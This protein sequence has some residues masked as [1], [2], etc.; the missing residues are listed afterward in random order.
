MI[1]DNA[2]DPAVH[3]LTP[4]Q[5]DLWWR[6]HREHA[7]G[8]D[9]GVLPCYRDAA[10]AAVRHLP[11][12]VVVV[13]LGAGGGEKEAAV[14]EA[15]VANRPSRD[16]CFVAVDV[17]LELALRSV[18]AIAQMGVRADPVVGDMLAM[19]ELGGW[20]DERYPRHRR[21]VTGFGI[22]PNVRPGE[23]W[24]L[25]GSVAGAQGLALV[26]ANLFT[27]WSE[28]LP[29]YDNPETAE[30]LGQVVVDWGLQG[31]LSPVRFEASTV[32]GVPAVV[33]VCTWLRDVVVT[34]DGTAVPVAAGSD[35]RL[36]F[37]LR[38]TP[39]QVRAL[40]F[41]QGWKVEGEFV[42]A[43]GQEGVWLLRRSLPAEGPSGYEGADDGPHG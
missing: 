14:V 16:V 35:L 18:E 21:L 10:A 6:V 34:L 38:F 13:G 41:T 4:A 23:L 7:P 29:Q 15:V 39:E 5:A 9:Q 43:G 33:A 20:L 42:G 24:P 32:D 1:G 25:I 12:D 31:H 27:S 2:L 30:W 36:F 19:S 8:S 3:Y 17:G 26:S 40:A 37:S 11:G 22:T 28:I